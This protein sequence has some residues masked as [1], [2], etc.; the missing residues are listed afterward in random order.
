MA[1]CVAHAL[2]AWLAAPVLLAHA[3][4]TKSIIIFSMGPKLGY[5]AVGGGG[6]TAV[7]ISTGGLCKARD[8]LVRQRQTFGHT[9]GIPYIH[10]PFGKNNVKRAR[11]LVGA[12]ASPE[13]APQCRNTHT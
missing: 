3:E 13:R 6:L 2:K 12:A 4:V 1:Q 10:K 8:T 5:P 9:I 11:G 7:A